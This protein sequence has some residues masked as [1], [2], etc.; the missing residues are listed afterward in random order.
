MSA[1]QQPARKP[2]PAATPPSLHQAPP[3]VHEV[4]ATAGEPLTGE[5]QRIVQDRF[6][7][8]TRSA[9][10]LADMIATAQASGRSE[11]QADSMADRVMATPTP[12]AQGRLDFQA[13]RLHTDGRAAEAARAVAAGAFTVGQHVVFGAGRYAPTTVPG[14]RLLAHELTH[15]VQQRHRPPDPAGPI[16]RSPDG[17]GP[18]DPGPAPPAGSVKSPDFAVMF[19]NQ[20]PP[21]AIKARIDV[22]APSLRPGKSASVTPLLFEYPVTPIDTITLYAVPDS[23][24]FETAAA[25]ALPPGKERDDQSMAVRGWPAPPKPAV[26]SPTGQLPAP[27]PASLGQAYTS[28]GPV[29]IVARAEGFG[30]TGTF[31]KLAVGA[32]STTIAETPGGVILIDAGTAG[33]GSGPIANATISRAKASIRGRKLVDVLFTHGHGDHTELMSRVAYEFE[34]ENLHINIAQAADPGL[35]WKTFS[36]DIAKNQRDF[37]E[38]HLREELEKERP[39]WE[40]D[41]DVPEEAA[42]EV[43]WKIYADEQVQLRMAKRQPINVDL[44]VP[45]PGGE[46]YVASA[47]IDKIDPASVEF[48]PG[49]TVGVLRT[50]TRSAIVN[51]DIADRADKLRKGGRLDDEQIDRY[52]TTYVLIIDNTMLALILPDMRV[53]DIR[54]IKARL[55]QEMARLGHT[56]ELRVWD[57]SHHLQKGFLGASADAKQGL[58][59]PQARVSKLGDLADLL[60]DLAGVKNAA[61]GLPTDVVTVSVNPAKI[62]RALAVVLQ[63]VGFAIVPAV[64]GQDVRLIEAMTPAG[65][66]VAGLASGQRYAGAAPADPLLRR[67]HAAVEELKQQVDGLESQAKKLRKKSD[68]AE[69]KRLNDEAAAARA[70]ITA[71]KERAEEYIRQVNQELAP[72][73]KA[74]KPPSSS[75]G[76]Q[77]P[78]AAQARALRGE[79]AGFDRPVVG[80][81]GS[82]TDVAVVLLGGDIPADARA[83]LRVIAE[84]RELQAQ[85]EQF[86]DATPPPELRARYLRALEAKRNVVRRHLA[87]ANQQGD[88]AAEERKVLRDE[89]TAV[90]KEVEVAIRAA[91]TSGDARAIKQ[92]LPNGKL[93]ETRIEVPKA[94]T[95][96]ERGARAAAEHLG[97]GMGAV[98]VYQ[99]LTGE[100][101]LEERYARNEAGLLETGVGTVQNLYG[102]TIGVRMMG[103]I[104]VHPGEFIV[105][106]ALDIA[107]TALRDYGTTEE[108]N[109]AIAYSVIRN[110]LSLGLMAA[111]SA[112]MEGGPLGM[113]VGMAIMFLADPILDALGVYDWLERKF[114]FMPDEVVE[115]TQ[116]LRKLL[117]EYRIIVGALEIS[118]RN[119]EQLTDVGAADPDATRKAAQQVIET[120]R[121]KAKHKEAELLV[122]FLDGYEEAKASYGGLPQLDEERAEFLSLMLRAQGPEAPKQKTD[123]ELSRATTAVELE[124]IG[125]QEANLTSR[126]KADAVFHTIEQG[127]TLQNMTSEQIHDMPQWEKMDTWMNKIQAEL[128]D[129]AEADIDWKFVAEKVGELDQMFGS[130]RYRLNPAVTGVERVTPMLPAGSTARYFYEQE[131]AQ[132]ENRFLYLR[133][134]IADAS[135]GIRQPAMPGY[136]DRLKA[137]ASPFP[138]SAP[139]NTSVTFDAALTG[140]EAAVKAFRAA[141][142]L[143]PPLGDGLTAESIASHSAVAATDYPRF[144][145][146]HPDYKRG[147]LR[148]RTLE[149]A[150]RISLGQARNLRHD[151]GTVAPEQEERLNRLISDEQ[152][153]RE[154]RSEEKSF[155][156]LEEIDEKLPKIRATE[157]IEIAGLL[158]Q[159]K[160]TKILS[161]AEQEAAAKGEL[162]PLHLSTIANRL[163]Q[164][165]QLRFPSPEEIKQGKT[166]VQGIY[167][168]VGL[169]DPVD[170]FVISVGGTDVDESDNVLVGFVRERGETTS[171]R[172]GHTTRVEVTPLNQAAINLFGGTQNETLERNL[173]SPATLD[174]VRSGL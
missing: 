47:P 172:Y 139:A 107:Q 18:Q 20:A 33:G 167:K 151:A 98:M 13:V 169:Y 148:L 32:G 156:Y 9:P 134:A 85:L 135:A 153:A 93:V 42:R 70:K 95:A 159:K 69:K 63:S 38:R 37:L 35:D 21:P 149:L 130:A 127:L 142:L 116:K 166:E 7:A 24:L 67:A 54:A 86:K 168:V 40:K 121:T 97:R 165:A 39:D 88:E 104:H 48:D 160:D 123:E 94:P 87:Q 114:A 29:E 53:G 41:H 81:L 16:A 113:I 61:G 89:M 44:Q 56:A 91:T 106:A 173:L 84:V 100:A 99:H 15:V 22:A 17:R 68:Q 3:V 71:I 43:Q 49:Q 55:K 10:S 14:Q 60:A 76:A 8:F 58:T 150:M 152:A 111:G 74:I 90:N 132:R 78:A 51:P 112:L 11:E 5:T 52:A 136:L 171:G 57:I 115:V 105:M 27:A 124:A 31:T 158:G 80:R 108:R 133:G 12:S 117:D 25:A 1:M 120:H 163:A 28:A 92:R 170:L 2:S 154:E 161:P 103:A 6:G 144:V 162:R 145:N 141:L 128:A 65:R 19:E 77:E 118:E 102:M 50:P 72:E 64:T 129:T 109:A 110:A 125:V 137:M 36:Q 140:A 23:E 155:L 138:A 174:D 131:L 59:L 157:N 26:T 46:M 147:L 146:S 45:G 34:L 143:Q 62:D 66:R 122:A 101:E 119:A 164:I 83:D 79:L 75:S 4:L 82:F 96:F 73:G 30:I 126:E